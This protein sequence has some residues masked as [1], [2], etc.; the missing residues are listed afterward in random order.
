MAAAI[1]AYT[2][3]CVHVASTNILSSH[4]VTFMVPAFRL[5]ATI[6]LALIS[7]HS[8]YYSVLRHHILTSQTLQCGISLVS[9]LV[10]LVIFYWP[11]EPLNK[12]SPLTIATG[13]PLI[14]CAL[15]LWHWKTTTVCS[16]VCLSHYLVTSRSMGH[17]RL[18]CMC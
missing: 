16:P 1:S 4:R 5:L 2:E 6:V 18:L 11:G 10:V 14:N 8:P 12:H 13:L 17:F 15:C 7:Y 9:L 3:V